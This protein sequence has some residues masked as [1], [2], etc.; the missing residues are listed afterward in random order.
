MQYAYGVCAFSK[1]QKPPVFIQLR[2]SEVYRPPSD[3][4]FVVVV[5]VIGQSSLEHW[6]GG[7]SEP[8]LQ[9]Y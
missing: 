9:C 2:I 6:P 5:V 7:E 8:T 3:S 4:S 1:N